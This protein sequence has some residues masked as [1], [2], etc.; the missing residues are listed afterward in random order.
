MATYPID[1]K[2]NVTV[3]PADKLAPG[4]YRCE[5]SVGLTDGSLTKTNF[6]GNGNTASQAE[7]D[8]ISQARDAVND[9]RILYRQAETSAK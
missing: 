6:T 1:D 8:A 7:N 5:A 2:H 3:R 4:H 9:G